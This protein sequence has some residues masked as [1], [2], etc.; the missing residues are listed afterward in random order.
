MEGWIF[1]L[2]TQWPDKMIIWLKTNTGIKKLVDSWQPSFYVAGS[3][4]DL[5]ELASRLGVLVPHRMEEWYERVDSPSK[6][7][8]LRV[9]YTGRRDCDNL[10]KLIW[11]LGREGSRYRMYNLDVPPDQLYFYEKDLFPLAYVEASQSNGRVSWKLLDSA[12]DTDYPQPPLCTVSLDVSTTDK[13][14]KLLRFNVPVGH[15][16]VDNGL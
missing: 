8:V 4:W 6:S 7:R 13:A 15:I 2:Y 14:S 5:D 11:S 9:F 10:K 12:Y 1:D 3:N 16:R